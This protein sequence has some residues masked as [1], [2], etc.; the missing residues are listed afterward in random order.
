MDN[1][2]IKFSEIS[3]ID[4][5]NFIFELVNLFNDY[6]SYVDIINYNGKNI[7]KEGTK[8]G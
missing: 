1:I 6:R 8:N 7:F 4:R 2:E 5:E 3:R